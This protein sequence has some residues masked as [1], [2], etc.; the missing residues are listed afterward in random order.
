[1]ITLYN[2]PDLERVL[3]RVNAWYE[4]EIVDRAPVNFGCAPEKMDTSVLDKMQFSSLEERWMSVDYQI[5]RIRAEISQQP[6]LGDGIPNAFFNLGPDYFTALYGGRIKFGEDTLWM[7]P[8]LDSYDQPVQMQMEGNRYF[9][10]IEQ[11][12]RIGLEELKGFANIGYTDLHPGLDAVCCMRGNQTLCFDLFEQPDGIKRVGMQTIQ[13][14]EKLFR[15]YN[16]LVTE[17]G[18]LSISWMGIASEESMH[19]PSCDFS[20]LISTPQFA[21]FGMPLLEREVHFAKHNVFHMDGPGVARHMDLICAV[22]EIQAVQ[23]MPGAGSMEVM[24]WVPHIKQLRA[25]GKSV[26]VYLTPEEID[27]FTAAMPPQ[28][29]YLMCETSDREVQRQVLKKVEQWR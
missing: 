10:T 24:Q 25:H 21:E 2:K 12:T 1:M 26:V 11:M 29:L 18:Q 20:F 22:P 3:E 9:D 8:F 16:R 17:H 27:E 5:A 4:G 7:E 6:I 28:G 19:I 15:H 23:W 14:Y 13:D